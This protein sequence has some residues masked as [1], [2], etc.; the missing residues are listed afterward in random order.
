MPQGCA[1]TRPRDPTTRWAGGSE[2]RERPA[3]TSLVGSETVTSAR[4][5]DFRNHFTEKRTL[6]KTSLRPSGAAWIS[7]QIQT[8]PIL[9]TQVDSPEGQTI[10][11]QRA[12]PT[13]ALRE[14]SPWSQCARVLPDAGSGG[15]LLRAARAPDPA[16]L[17][18]AHA[19]PLHTV[20]RSR[21]AVPRQPPVAS[22]ACEGG[23]A[24]V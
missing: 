15:F 9:R 13:R 7:P 14:K 10:P 1:V 20:T 19:S 11:F 16:C 23:A 3:T 6:P 5:C 21:C 12:R 22:S 8:R 4:F 24:G 18:D 2:S 17:S